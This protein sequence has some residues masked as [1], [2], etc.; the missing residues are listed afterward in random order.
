MELSY[1]KLTVLWDVTI[2]SAIDITD[3]GTTCCLQTPEYSNH[4]VTN[5]NLKSCINFLQLVPTVTTA[6]MSFKLFCHAV[7]NAEKYTLLNDIQALLLRAEFRR[8]QLKW[9]KNIL[10]LIWTI[11]IHS[12]SLYKIRIECFYIL[13]LFIRIKINYIMIK[14]VYKSIYLGRETN[15]EG[16]SNAKIERKTQNTVI[17]QFKARIVNPENS[18]C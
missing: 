8:T 10:T 7:S 2:Y 6:A 4:L 1:I 11:Y 17:L 13:Y 12:S 15:L 3:T 18:H 9:P 14:E 5:V 16:K